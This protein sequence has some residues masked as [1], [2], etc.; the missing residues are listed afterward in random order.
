MI[1]ILIIHSLSVFAA[2]IHVDYQ[3]KVKDSSSLTISIALM[4]DKSGHAV[5]RIP[6]LGIITSLSKGV[7]ADGT[8]QKGEFRLTSAPKNQITISYILTNGDGPLTYPYY[9]RPVVHRD[10]FYF[11]GTNGLATPATDDATKVVVTLTYIGLPKNSFLGN[12]FFIEDKG[13]FTTTLANLKKGIFC[14]GNYR[15]KHFDDVGRKVVLI[16]AGNIKGTDEKAFSSVIDELRKDGATNNKLP[17]YFS[18]MIPYQHTMNR[19]NKAVTVYASSTTL[20]TNDWSIV[21]KE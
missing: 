2:T 11:S 5:V 20:K 7:T 17:F 21:L 15:V 14:G 1:T 13:E 3:I 4:T 6:N 19:S 16:I 12:S 18:L 10:Y 9:L 8:G